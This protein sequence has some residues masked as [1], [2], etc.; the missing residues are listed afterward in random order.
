MFYT[1]CVF[2]HL[3]SIAPSTADPITAERERSPLDVDS[4]MKDV[5]TEDSMAVAKASED[6]MAYCAICY[7]VSA[8]TF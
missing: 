4:T 1:L 8:R 6:G 7:D 2:K 3:V 5:N